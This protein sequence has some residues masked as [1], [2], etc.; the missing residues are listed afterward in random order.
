MKGTKVNVPMTW[1]MQVIGNSTRNPPHAP[2]RGIEVF[3]S[4]S[5]TELVNS[6][7]FSC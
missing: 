3:S 2:Q 7:T 6:I 5:Y 4:Y 1:T